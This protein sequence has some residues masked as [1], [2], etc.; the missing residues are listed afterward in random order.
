MSSVGDSVGEEPLVPADQ[1]VRACYDG[2]LPFAKAAVASGASVD[3]KGWLTAWDMSCPLAAA[4]MGGHRDVVVWLLSHGAD[5]NG[6]AVM[7]AGAR[8]STAGMLQLLMDAGGD[9][10]LDSGMRP[11]LFTAAVYNDNDD[12]VSLLLAQ[13]T[14]DLTLTFARKTAEQFAHVKGQHGRAETITAEVSTVNLAR[15]D[16]PGVRFCRVLVSP[17]IPSPLLATLGSRLP[18]NALLYLTEDE[19]SEAGTASGCSIGC[20][21]RVAG[22]VASCVAWLWYRAGS[23]QLSGRVK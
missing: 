5:P 7:D 10:N 6:D 13:P 23:R 17:G 11:L 3:A 19:A 20:G 15:L 1:L 22:R 18:A 8:D 21:R 16:S 2:D 4:V 9:I 12:L 14:L